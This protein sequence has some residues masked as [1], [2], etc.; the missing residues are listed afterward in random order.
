MCSLIMGWRVWRLAVRPMVWFPLATGV[1]FL[2]T[3]TVMRTYAAP[4]GRT[5]T[6]ISIFLTAM[7]VGTVVVTSVLVPG[8]TGFARIATIWL[9]LAIPAGCLPFV[10]R[11]SAISED[12]ILIRR[13]WWTT[14][15]ERAGLK[16]AE[17]VADA[18]RGSIR[19]CGNGGGYSITGWY[20][21]KRLGFYRAYVTD[22]KRTVVL[23][24]VRKTVVLSP[25]A[26][27]DFAGELGMSQR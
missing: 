26:P 9:P 15:L 1:G 27:E 6:C 3:K 18:M 4:W 21:S 10:V 17:V 7:C 24:F 20:W 23:R 14:R 16:S 5:L 22:L 2:L 25:D 11:G 19:T 13:L 12:A 8:L